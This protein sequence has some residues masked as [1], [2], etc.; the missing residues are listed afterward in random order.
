MT[1][2]VLKTFQLTI[3][4]GKARAWTNHPGSYIDNRLPQKCCLLEFLTVKNGR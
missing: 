4:M 1:Q 2:D 3:T